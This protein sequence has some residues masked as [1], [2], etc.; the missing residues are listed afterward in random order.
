MRYPACRM[1]GKGSFLGAYQDGVPGLSIWKE[2]Q[3]VP[4]NTLAAEIY[5]VGNRVNLESGEN[6]RLASVAST[7]SINAPTQD[8]LFF[9]YSRCKHARIFEALDSVYPVLRETCGPVD[10]A[11]AMAENHKG[12]TRVGT[13]H[14]LILH[15]T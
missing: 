14:L 9:F 6:M 13:Q 2:E 5:L 8:C 12:R 15:M 7:M 1:A 4:I 10:E 3:L 11:K